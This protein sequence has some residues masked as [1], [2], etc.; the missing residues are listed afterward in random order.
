MWLTRNNW[1]VREGNQS[2]NVE[3]V[4]SKQQP[5]GSPGRPASPGAGSW[6]TSW[7]AA[8]SQLQKIVRTVMF[9]T[10]I[11]IATKTKGGKAKTAWEILLF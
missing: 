9:P 1:E 6:A 10:D 8:A 2:I 11:P 4:L 3:H 5:E 7:R